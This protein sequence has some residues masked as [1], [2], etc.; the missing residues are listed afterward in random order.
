MRLVLLGPPGAGKGTQATA[1]SKMFNIPHISTGDLFRENLKN[2]TPLGLKAKAYMDEG[3]L[4]P[5]ELVIALVEDRI[6]RDDC[7]NGYLLDGFPRT[8]AQASALCAFEEKLGRS[9]DYAINIE[10]PESLL[11]E[12][13]VGRRSCPK[14]GATYHV[15]YNPPKVE[16]ICDIC[17][18]TLKQRADD[19]ED[20]AKT[21]LQVYHAETAP[22]VDF[23][24]FKNQL[25]NINGNQAPDQVGSDIRIALEGGIDK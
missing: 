23:Y 18:E 12:R 19:C 13:M 24:R 6:I 22:L 17:G 1:I 25:I 5:D 9:M 8:V 10:V 14:C 11:V 21:R 16:G 7:T 15:K 20:T 2:E 4:V 3:K